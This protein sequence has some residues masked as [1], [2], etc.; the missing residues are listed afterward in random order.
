MDYLIK[1]KYKYKCKNKSNKKGFSL[2]E[3]LVVIG[4]FS[5]LILVSN[6]AYVN[7]KASSNLKIGTNNLVESLRYA[8]VN[9]QAVK[10]DSPW[11]V[12]ILSNQVVIFKGAGYLTRDIAADQILKFPQGIVA[13][14]SSEFVFQKLI[15]STTG[16]TVVLTNN[17]GAKN[18]IVNAKGTIT[19]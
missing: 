13:S 9:S 2:V 10:N 4:I 3:L 19:Y 8:Q 17:A 11:G 16:G 7:F 5:I 15:G 6:S 12:E 1:Y 14:G 18:I